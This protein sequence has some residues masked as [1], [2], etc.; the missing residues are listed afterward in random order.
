MISFCC[1]EEVAVCWNEQYAVGG[2]VEQTVAGVVAMQRS[3]E[4]KYAGA[5]VFHNYVTSSS[6]FAD[7]K[8]KKSRPL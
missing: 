6:E 1:L 4:S 5:H 8:L 7:S 3:Y 2:H